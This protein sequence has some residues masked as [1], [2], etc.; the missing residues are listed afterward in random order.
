M[1]RTQELSFTLSTTGWSI[2]LNELD[3]EINNK[4]KVL[5]VC[6]DEELKGIRGELRGLEKAKELPGIIE[7][8]GEL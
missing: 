8:R 4:L 2:Y 5:R 1:S 6:P 7:S 3:K